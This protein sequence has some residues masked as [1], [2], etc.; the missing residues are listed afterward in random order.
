MHTHLPELAEQY[1]VRWLGV[2]GSYV[3]NE[4][5]PDSDLDLLVEFDDRGLTL[6]QVI[7]LQ[8]YLSD[9]LGVSRSGRTRLSQADD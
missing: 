3:R 9:L 1:G 6:L 2:F 5:Q 4:Q 7:G 8:D